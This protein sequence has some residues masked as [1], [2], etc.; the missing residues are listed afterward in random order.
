MWKFL[1][2]DISDVVSSV[3]RSKFSTTEL[4]NLAN[5]IIEMEGLMRPAILKKVGFERY[6][7]I[8]GDLEYYASVIANEKDPRIEMINAF[9]INQECENIALQQIKFLSPNL[10]IPVKEETINTEKNLEKNFNEFKTS[11]TNQL[12]KMQE[13]HQKDIQNIREE[14]KKAIQAFGETIGKPIPTDIVPTALSSTSILEILNACNTDQLIKGRIS[15]KDAEEFLKKRA[16]K[17]FKS[18]QDI[19]DRVNGVA[20]KKLIKLI[21]SI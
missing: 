9:V 19:I 20:E 16:E 6:E 2:V 15:E 17:P 14:Y 1:R 5:L 10:T 8:Y 4:D 18:L 13:D 11:I 21:D 12:S 3:D 7:V